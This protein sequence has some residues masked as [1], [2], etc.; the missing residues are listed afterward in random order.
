MAKVVQAV[1]T[2][3]AAGCGLFREA[4]D[5]IVGARYALRS[6]SSLLSVSLFFCSP[7]FLPLWV[8]FCEVGVTTVL[9]LAHW[10][11]RRWG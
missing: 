3:V 2:T 5:A 4:M 6:Q 11:L 10:E 8:G 1:V 7:F 9:G